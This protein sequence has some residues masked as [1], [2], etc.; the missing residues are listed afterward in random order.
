ML[1][2]QEY[3]EDL[4]SALD[5]EDLD[6]VSAGHSDL[7]DLDSALG[8]EDHLDLV[9]AGHSDFLEDPL[10]AALQAGL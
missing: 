10:S 8:L 4:D 5:L 3:L 6:L 2:I 9:S 7:E 1:K